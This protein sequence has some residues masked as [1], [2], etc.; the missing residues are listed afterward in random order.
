LADLDSEGL[1]ILGPLM[2][3]RTF[4]AGSVIFDQGDAADAIYFVLSGHAT[5]VLRTADPDRWTRLMAVPA[6]AAFG[7]IAALD[8]G[9]RTSRV[10]ADTDVVA[11]VL[12]ITDLT[13]LAGARA[14]VVGQLYQGIAK[15]LAR[16]LRNSVR[17][18][19]AL[20][21]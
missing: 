3:Q 7:E 18:I 17:E 12:T 1:R 13:A 14:D 10:V 11:L 5:V 8:G 20:Q 21:A 9:T 15:A 6:G 2:F 16:R 19:L 4:P